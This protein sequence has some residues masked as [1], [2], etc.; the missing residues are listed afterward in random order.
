MKF[1]LLSS[2]QLGD[3]GD[4]LERMLS[5]NKSIAYIPNACDY[6][7]IN[8]DKKNAWEKA[9]IENLKELWLKV[10]YLLISKIS[11]ARLMIWEKD[12]MNFDE[13]SWEGGIPSFWDR[14]WN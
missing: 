5:H 6:T 3:K 14:Q 12:Y 1:Y 9:D 4:D 13:S 11:L 10:T 2:F 7:N 8:W